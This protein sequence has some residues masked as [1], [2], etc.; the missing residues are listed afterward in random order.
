M[1]PQ[2]NNGKH[3]LEEVQGAVQRRNWLPGGQ[4]RGITFEE[5]RGVMS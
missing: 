4:D 1:G 5:G 3:G 2:T